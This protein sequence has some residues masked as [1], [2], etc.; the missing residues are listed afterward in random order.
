MSRVVWF[1]LRWGLRLLPLAIVVAFLH[2]SLPG[3]DVVRIVGTEVNR[4]DR[5]AK[6][7]AEQDAVSG[8]SVTRDVRFINTVRPN[9]DPSVYRNEDTDWGFPW[10]FKFDSGNLQARAQD[11]ISDKADPEWVLLT[12]YGWRIEIFS[13]FP[14]AVAIKPVDG[15]DYTAIP[16]FS[17]VFLLALAV[18]LFFLVR[19]GLR[20]MH[21]LELDERFENAGNSAGQ[22]WRWTKANLR[23][24]RRKLIGPE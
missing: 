3:H 23:D 8:G 2:Y 10:Y 17:I 7:P 12:H 24:A 9:G 19:G 6:A 13:M 15:P 18:L 4:M 14:N 5:P 22:V 11:L 21:R 16:W 20:F 1:S